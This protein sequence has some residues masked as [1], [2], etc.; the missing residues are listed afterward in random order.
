MNNQSACKERAL[1]LALHLRVP[2]KGRYSRFYQKHRRAERDAR[3]RRV[4]ATAKRLQQANQ[5]ES[6]HVETKTQA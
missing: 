4:V 2:I 6:D 3:E 1:Q 5:R